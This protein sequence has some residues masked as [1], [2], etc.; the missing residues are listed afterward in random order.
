M[1]IPSVYLT[2]SLIYWVWQTSRF[3][4]YDFSF[5]PLILEGHSG[6]AQ[7]LPNSYKQPIAPMENA[8]FSKRHLRSNI[9]I[10]ILGLQKCLDISA[11]LIAMSNAILLPKQAQ[12]IIEHHGNYPWPS[13]SPP[14]MHDTNQPIIFSPKRLQEYQGSQQKR[15]QNQRIGFYLSVFR[16][17][18]I[19]PSLL[20]SKP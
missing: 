1:R 12:R 2:A 17:P 5:S 18:Q 20:H 19:P 15:W 3:R 7:G 10:H 13:Q 14:Q 16:S 6:S 9:A 4:G 11:R 8:V